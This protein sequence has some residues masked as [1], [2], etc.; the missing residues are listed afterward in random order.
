MNYVTGVYA[1]EG[2]RHWFEIPRVL[3]VKN[4]RAAHWVAYELRIANQV[5][6]I[7]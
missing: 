5:W 7:T 3:G 4:I 2:G 1:I 6:F